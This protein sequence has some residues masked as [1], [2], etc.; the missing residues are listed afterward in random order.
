MVT[1]KLTIR[2]DPSDLDELREAAIEDKRSVN[3]QVL[4]YIRRALDKRSTPEASGISST[5][6]LNST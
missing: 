4:F 6:H 2:I 1:A 5:G 3:Q